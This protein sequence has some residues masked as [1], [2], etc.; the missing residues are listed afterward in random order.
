MRE[1]SKKQVLEAIEMEKLT[2]YTCNPV[3][4]ADYTK[5]MSQHDGFIKQVC[6]D[7]VVPCTVIIEGHGE[8]EVGHLRQFG[9]V[10]Q[11]SFQTFLYV[12]V[13]YW[14]KIVLTRLIYTIALHLQLIINNLVNRES[15]KE[16]SAELVSPS[17]GIESLLQEPPIVASKHGKFNS[18]IQVLRESK[19]VVAKII[20]RISR[21]G[22]Y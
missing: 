8:V 17:G 16:I 20:D 12:P 10:L 14:W 11:N 15:E 4:M 1:N 21:Y 18:S 2:D 3:Y 13:A 7:E 9:H 6:D 19:E 5:L 22:D